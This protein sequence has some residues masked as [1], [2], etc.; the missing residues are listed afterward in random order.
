M[1]EIKIRTVE[2]YEFKGVTYKTLAEA[3]EA[4][5][6]DDLPAAE[7]WLQLNRKRGYGEIINDGEYSI[8]NVY[9]EDSNCDMGGSHIEP[10]LG[11]VEGTYRQAAEWAVKHT[12]FYAWGGGGSIKRAV[13]RKVI[14]L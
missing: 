11:A 6:K 8:W 4:K 12:R 7:K 2:T 14:K 9:G 5:R 10:F 3:Q 13:P 1:T